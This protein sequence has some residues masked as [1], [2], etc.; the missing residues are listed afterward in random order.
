M[1]TLIEGFGKI[2]SLAIRSGTALGALTLLALALIVTSDVLTTRFLDHPIPG[3][4]KLSEAGLVLIL[5]LGLAVAT[6]NR[7]VSL[8]PG[9]RPGRGPAG[10]GARCCHR[11]VA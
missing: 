11:R 7:G 3:V 4:M 8:R 2:L 5:F 10:K 6:R 1:R 9:P